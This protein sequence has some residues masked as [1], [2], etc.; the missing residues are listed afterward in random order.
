MK[1]ILFLSLFLF[2][3]DCFGAEGGAGKDGKDFENLEILYTEKCRSPILSPNP[4][5]RPNSPSSI[6]DFKISFSKKTDCLYRDLRIP[7][8]LKFQ[9]SWRRGGFGENY[10]DVFLKFEYNLELSLY[11]SNIEL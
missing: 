2:S 9:K 4:F 11:N 1:K 3:V 10:S 7:P 5:L 8:P 6:L